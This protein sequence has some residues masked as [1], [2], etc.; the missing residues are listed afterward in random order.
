MILL[1]KTP[2]VMAISSPLETLFIAIKFPVFF[3][4]FHSLSKITSLMT[5]V[6]HWFHITL[7]SIALDR[8]NWL[9]KIHIYKIVILLRQTVSNVPLLNEAQS[10]LTLF[11]VQQELMNLSRK[12]IHAIELT[13][14]ILSIQR[15][16]GT[17]LVRGFT[18]WLQFRA[19]MMSERGKKGAKT[20]PR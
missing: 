19:H 12:F 5:I 1:K 11:P 6:Q 2:K 18:K 3:Y 13:R 10:S 8:K 20:R 16:R 4:Y 7:Q 9:Q 15:V 17:Q 14:S